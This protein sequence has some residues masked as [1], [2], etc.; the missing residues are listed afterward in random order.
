MQLEDALELALALALDLSF[1]SAFLGRRS[2]SEG[3]RL[4]SFGHRSLIAKVVYLCLP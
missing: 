3:N 1:A 2:F 4:L